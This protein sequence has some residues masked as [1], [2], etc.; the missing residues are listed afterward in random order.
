MTHD[1]RQELGIGAGPEVAMLIVRE[2]GRLHGRPVRNPERTDTSPL[3]KDLG[4][5][6]A[7][8]EDGYTQN[9]VFD[10]GCSTAF[11]D[12]VGHDLRKLFQPDVAMRDFDLAGPLN[13][14]RNQTLRLG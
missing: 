2:F 13:F 1:A 5:V 11:E 9:F 8:L 7:L 14:N 10:N 12:G 6:T 4:D 3:I